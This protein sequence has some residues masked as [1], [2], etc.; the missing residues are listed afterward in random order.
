[1]P[2]VVL[3]PHVSAGT[4]DAFLTKMRFVFA[5]LD[6]FWKGDA[7]SKLGVGLGLFIARGIVEA[8]GGKISVESEVGRGTRFIFTRG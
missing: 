5:N 2:N 4:R 7:S 8:H 6:R 3:T 1:M